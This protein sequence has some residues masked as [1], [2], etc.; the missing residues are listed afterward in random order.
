VNKTERFMKCNLRKA[1]DVFISFAI[2]S[3][4][5]LSLTGCKEAG[6]AEKHDS[7]TAAVDSSAAVIYFTKYEH[8]FGRVKEDEKIGCIFTFENRGS[9]PLVISN[10]VTS[11]GCT[12]PKYDRN[13]IPAGGSGK[14]EVVFNTS[15][16]KGVQTKTISVHSNATVPVVI[17]KITAEII[18]N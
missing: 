6:S 7:A 11:C 15:G 9:S 2:F 16:Y 1:S 13:P 4:F 5:L 8:E 3:L 12:V 10:A 14:L 17:L 18:T